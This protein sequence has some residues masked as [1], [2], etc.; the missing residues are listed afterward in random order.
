MLITHGTLCFT[1]HFLYQSVH[2]IGLTCISMVVLSLPEIPTPWNCK[3][4]RF[5]SA[6]FFSDLVCLQ[7]HVCRFCL[8]RTW[9][10]GKR[11]NGVIIDVM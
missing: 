6:I 4:G 7:A 3:L 5:L 11:Q 10:P 2:Y 9:T 1:S 8:S